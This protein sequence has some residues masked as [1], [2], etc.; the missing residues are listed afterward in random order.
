MI[1]GKH[2]FLPSSDKYRVWIFQALYSTLKKY[3]HTVHIFFFNFLPPYNYKLIFHWDFIWSTNWQIIV[4]ILSKKINLKC[5]VHLHS[6]P[7]MNTSHQLRLLVCWG[8]SLL[9]LHRIYGPFFLAKELKLSQT[10]WTTSVS[11]FFIRSL[12]T[13]TEKHL[14]LYFDW[15]IQPW[16]LLN[17]N[18]SIVALN[19][20]LGPL[21]CVVTAFN[22]QYYMYILFVF[23]L[24]PFKILLL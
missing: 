7:C 24:L 1:Q 12:A 17:L 15:P 9:E 19:S 8:R 23:Y 6:A 14:R 5:G 22:I 18:N 2:F 10:G 20:C 4:K 13:Y 16:I 3:W 11:S 21:T